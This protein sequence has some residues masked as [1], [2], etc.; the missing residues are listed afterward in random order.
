ME[1]TAGWDGVGFTV[2]E[3]FEQLK[4]NKA[5]RYSDDFIAS[6]LKGSKYPS[7]YREESM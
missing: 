6:S 7:H 5:L 2:A 4:E 1:K 3:I